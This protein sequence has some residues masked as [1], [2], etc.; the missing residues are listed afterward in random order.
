MLKDLK[1]KKVVSSTQPAAFDSQKKPLP[2][3]EMPEEKAEPPD[4][5]KLMDFLF[6]KKSQ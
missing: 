2:E 3:T 4:P 6:K 5:A 1:A